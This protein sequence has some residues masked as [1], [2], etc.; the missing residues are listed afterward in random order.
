MAEQTKVISLLSSLQ[1]IHPSFVP[2]LESH[3]P[4]ARPSTG[5]QSQL[6]KLLNRLNIVLLT[7]DDSREKRAACEAAEEMIKQ[8]EEGWVLAGWGKGWLGG[9]LGWIAST[10]SP[11]PSI[12]PYL[13]LLSTL[14]LTS[15]HFPSFERQN[16]H[17]IM[18]KLSVSLGRL[19]Q[20]CLAEPQPDWD[21]LLD[22]LNSIQFILLHSPANFRPST[23]TLKPILLALALLIPTPTSPN[24]SIPAEIRTASAKLLACCHV[25]AGKAQSPASWAADMKDL[26]GGI[27]KAAVG[28]TTD[29][30]EA[31]PVAVNPPPSPNTPELPIDPL[32]RV[33][34]SL[35]WLEGLT[36]AVLEML[37]FPTNRPVQVPVAG[38]VSAGLRFLSLTLDT[39]TVSYISPQHHALLVASLPRIWSI[40]MQLLGGI[41]LA[42]EDHL[43]PHLSNILDHSVWLLERIPSSMSECQ[44][45][46]LKFHTLL[47]TLYPPSLVPT[48]YPT[49]LLRF[50]VSTFSPLLE[51]K[52]VSASAVASKNESG[53]GKRGKKRARNA[54]DGLVGDLEGKG[55]QSLGT[56][57]VKVILQALKL[58]PI[59]HTTP[60]ISPSLLTLSIRLHLS[61]YLALPSLFSSVFPSFNAKSE[62]LEAVQKVLESVLSVGEGW[63]KGYESV[64]ISVLGHKSQSSI[65]KI[66]HP[67]LPPMLRAQPALREL[68][69]FTKEGDEEKK[70]RKLA[71][72]GVDDEE[73]E[74]EQEEEEETVRLAPAPPQIASTTGFASFALPSTREVA[75]SASVAT[76]APVVPVA[77]PIA[78]P[79]VAPPPS[80]ALI[81]AST[82]APAATPAVDPIPSQPEQTTS[83]TT[84]SSFI[85]FTSNS[86]LATTTSKTNETVVKQTTQ[87]EKMEVDDEDEGIPEL[88]SGSDDGLLEDDDE[89]EED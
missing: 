82:S 39:P 51:R 81:P 89:E 35:D 84:S 46:L 47:L 9:C 69:F 43:F 79:S 77:A 50:C 20:R 62:I 59:L 67:K 48:D 22:I 30:W 32:Q 24:P 68:H 16:V 49:R 1:F 75:S 55:R 31:D 34:V 44:T 38:I 27:G 85:S 36:E 64:I 57:E 26:L 73:I 63:S 71:R 72:L 74:A 33:P 42:V 21:V 60:L 10:S 2:L 8:D 17:P 29:A 88:D 41:A 12:P 53:G 66:V 37:R 14:V 87:M 23:A 25:T 80:P 40:G 7:K 76:T 56:G 54:E 28:I 15:S 58:S 65:D 19:L 5:S 3:K 61:L 52:D 70:E 6:N 78:A 86:T 83:T 18:G 45:Q 4:L 11:I 13:S